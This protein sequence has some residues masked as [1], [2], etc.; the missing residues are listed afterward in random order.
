MSSCP[1]WYHVVLCQDTAV[2]KS[3]SLCQL[4]HLPAARF[5]RGCDD[6]AHDSWSGDDE[7]ADE[8]ARNLVV[9][10]TELHVPPS[11]RTQASRVS[12]HVL[13]MAKRDAVMPFTSLHV[14]PAESDLGL[15]IEAGP[16]QGV[17][18]GTLPLLHSSM[19][20]LLSL[21]AYSV[22]PQ[23]M[24]MRL[25]HL[26]VSAVCV[27]VCVCV[28]CMHAFMYWG[29]RGDANALY[30][31]ACFSS[32]TI[33]IMRLCSCDSTKCFSF[34]SCIVFFCMATSSLI[35]C[36][37]STFLSAKRKARLAAWCVV[38]TNLLSFTSTSRRP[39]PVKPLPV[40]TSTPPW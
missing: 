26:H 23:H 24:R 21:L 40:L 13:E 2:R 16:Y 27:C 10:E 17:F 18:T 9:S 29:G 3:A 31:C 38:L 37:L 1:S 25:I 8:A 22:G 30:A 32:W 19:I 34:F 20:Y 33:T 11:D 12:E 28:C 4:I 36:I 15:S 39:M 6:G 5:C 14:S 7:C 35:S